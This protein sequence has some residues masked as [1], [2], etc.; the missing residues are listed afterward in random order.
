MAGST[1]ARG[2]PTTKQTMGTLQA[3]GAG[4][5]CRKA[6]ARPAGQLLRFRG[7]TTS[8]CFSPI[9]TAA[10]TR[11]WGAPTTQQ[12]MGTLRALGPGEACRKAAASPAGRLLRFRGGTTS[13][14]FSPI[15]TAASIR[16]WG[17]PTTQQTM[18]T[19]QALGP[20]EA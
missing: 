20:G 1:R 13:P 10:S 7:G 15:P 8:P 17:T 3:L 18:G 4:E 5:A 12:T 11:P 6:A 14:C 16:P 9:P 2:T 19:L